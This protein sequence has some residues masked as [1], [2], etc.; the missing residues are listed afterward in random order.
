MTLRL[1]HCISSVNP[2]H[3]GPIEGLKQLAAANRTIGNSVEVVCLDR[4]EDAWVRACPI[5]CHALGPALG[6]YGYSRRLVPS[7]SVVVRQMLF[8]LSSGT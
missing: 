1:L 8:P 3:G 6:R 5:R 2:E 4:P 7:T